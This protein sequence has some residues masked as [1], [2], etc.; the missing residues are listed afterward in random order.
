MPG[1]PA[2]P[3]GV[4]LAGS[5]VLAIVIVAAGTRLAAVGLADPATPA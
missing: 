1:T 4:M 3:S 5:G 2:C